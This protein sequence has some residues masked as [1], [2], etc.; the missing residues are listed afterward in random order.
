MKKNSGG[1]L[2]RYFSISTRIYSTV[3]IGEPSVSTNSAQGE[4]CFGLDLACN[5]GQVVFRVKPLLL[6]VGHFESDDQCAV[7]PG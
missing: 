2:P 3:Q 6:G 5:H 7:R 1:I 4:F